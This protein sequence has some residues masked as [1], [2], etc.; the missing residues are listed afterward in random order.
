MKNEKLTMVVYTVPTTPVANTAAHVGMG[1][2]VN[3]VKHSN[4]HTIH[5]L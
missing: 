2:T 1:V 4:I 5:S 3:K